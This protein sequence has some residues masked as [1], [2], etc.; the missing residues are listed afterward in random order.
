MSNIFTAFL[1]TQPVNN[2]VL[3]WLLFFL[4]SIVEPG[5]CNPDTQ[6]STINQDDLVLAVSILEDILGLDVPD[7]YI[8]D[9][10]DTTVRQLAEKIRDLRKLPDDV[11]FERLQQNQIMCKAWTNKN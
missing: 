1:N 4:N 5:E 9:N 7:E 3:W 10:Q 2:H 8:L 6:I 11:Y